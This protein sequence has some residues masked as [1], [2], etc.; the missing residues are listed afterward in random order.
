MRKL[1]K[2]RVGI[3]VFGVLLLF[4]AVY[5]M[6]WRLGLK[7]VDGG[8]ITMQVGEELSQDVE[9]YLNLTWYLPFER[10][11][12]ISEC[13]LTFSEI[14]YM[15]SENRCPQIG[16]YEGTITYHDETYPISIQVSDDTPPVVECQESV[17]YG[18]SSFQIEDL[19]TVSDNSQEECDIQIDGDV[20]VSKMGTYT[21]HVRA[22]DPYE[23]IQEE[24]FEVEVL[25]L[26]APEIS[27]KP[28]IAYLNETFDPLY[29]VSATDDVDG[30][31]T[32]QIE[33]SGEVNTQQAGTYSLTY[34]VS[35]QSGNE[36]T[37]ERDVVVKERETSYRISDVPM[38][39]QLPDY[40]N[41]CESASSTMLLQYY[42]YD[43]TIED[44]IAEVP[45]I[46]LEYKDGR[47][48][49]ANPHEAFTGSMS[50]RGYGIYVEPMVEVLENMIDEQNGQHTVTNLTGSSL[51][52]LLV[53]VEMG[54]PIQI[55]ATASLQTYEQSG[56]QEWY[57]K[58][59]D[60]EYTDETVTFPV[61]E[62]CLVL[63]G[64]DEEHVV[65][66][67]PLQ[68]LT[69]WDRDAFEIAFEDMESQAIMIDD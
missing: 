58:T 34:T 13:Q 26:K 66:N 19:I 21:V 41:G 36:T 18:T 14:K 40:H 43:V 32:D 48:Y 56:K 31:C 5:I 11:N 62:H 23:N 60:G 28:Q 39:L 38:V 53:Y 17:A 63:I 6:I 49:G 20:D 33:V 47:L 69:I 27:I 3:A 57:I 8:T 45:I 25:D 9:D 7:L 50:S 68:G 15:D 65:L 44:V 46:P 22:E 29:E 30:D 12:I 51:E 24:T 4:M 16:E 64:F 55:W 59:L 35:D 42:G 1:S 37:V 67:N 61:S 54:H 10:E 52:D 2:K